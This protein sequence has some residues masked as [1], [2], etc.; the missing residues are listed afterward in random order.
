MGLFSTI[1]GAV[2]GPL[3]GGLFS[4]KQ[5]S[6]NRDFQQKNSDTAYQRAMADMRSAGLNPI[7]AGNN[8]CGRWH[9]FGRIVALLRICS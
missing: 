5:A 8:F 2:A 4:S 7:L 1:A 9:T 3:I 6:D